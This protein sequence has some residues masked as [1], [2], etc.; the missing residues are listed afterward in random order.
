MKRGEAGGV[1]GKPGGRWC[2]ELGDGRLGGLRKPVGGAQQRVNRGL[3]QRALAI[4]RGDE[5]F[6]DG[7]RE[8]D[9]EI[10]A[11]NARRA[12]QRMGGAGGGLDFFGIGGIGAA[13]NESLREDSRLCLGLGAV[14]VEQGFVQRGIA[15]G[16][17]IFTG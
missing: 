10:K 1:L 13:L 8:L 11:D 7:V 9:R 6:L 16:W 5:D 15:H 3:V 12:L 4:L 14:E 17:K 2:G